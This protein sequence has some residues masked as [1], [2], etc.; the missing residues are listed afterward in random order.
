M[1]F[2][3]RFRK[4]WQSGN[5]F[6]QAAMETLG[7]LECEEIVWGVREDEWAEASVQPPSDDR[8][9]VVDPR[10]Y[11]VEVVSADEAEERVLPG[12]GAAEGRAWL[13][14]LSFNLGVGGRRC[15]EQ[16][17][18]VEEDS[19]DVEFAQQIV[20]RTFDRTVVEVVAVTD[21]DGEWQVA[22]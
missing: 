16:G 4:R 8:S 9:P 11:D 22:R 1:H 5:E 13:A 20:E 10:L 7:E 19:V 15:G 3:R 17:A 12:D 18:A 2:G 6:A 21:F 14:A